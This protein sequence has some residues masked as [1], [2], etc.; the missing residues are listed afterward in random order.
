VAAPIERGRSAAERQTR[1]AIDTAGLL[2]QALGHRAAQT[3]PLPQCNGK[4]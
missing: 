4:T 2:S 1:I 3:P